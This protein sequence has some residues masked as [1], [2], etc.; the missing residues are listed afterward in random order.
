VLAG[1]SRH[2]A[3]EGV[4]LP[5]GC[6]V[7][8]SDGSTACACVSSRNLAIGVRSAVVA[9]LGRARDRPSKCP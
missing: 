7:I 9:C 8:S 2:E 6:K 3:A 1:K 5:A 4:L